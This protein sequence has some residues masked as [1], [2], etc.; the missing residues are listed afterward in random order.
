MYISYYDSQE[1]MSQRACDAIT[2]QLAQKPDSLLCAATGG[3]PSRTY[4]LLHHEA[5]QRPGLFAQMKLIKLDE[6]GGLP[7]N[8]PASCE[9]YLQTQLIK[10]LGISRDRYLAFQS[11]AADPAKEC[12]RIQQELSRSGPIDLCILGL[13]VNGH[14]AFNEPSDGLQATCHVAELSGQSLQHAMVADMTAKPAYGYTLGM[15]DILQAKQIILLITGKHKEKATRDLFSGKITSHLPASFLSL[16]PN[17]F[18][19]IDRQAV[20]FE[21]LT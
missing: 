11:D 8:H 3:S 20:S 2:A 21:K 18:C 12:T 4:A 13:G 5:G 19:L 17:A 6:W 9:T 1:A 7:P 14:I 10:P 16:H 15:A